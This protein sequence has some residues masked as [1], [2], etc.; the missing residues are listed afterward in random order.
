MADRNGPLQPEDYVEP[1]CVLCGE[2]YGEERVQAVPQ[3][4]DVFA[5]EGYQF[6]VQSMRG[7]RVSM[8]RVTAP[9]AE[10]AQ[11]EE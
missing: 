6:R 9:E 2:P 8:L 11:S 3:P 4:G 10:E 5:C 1:R 7:R